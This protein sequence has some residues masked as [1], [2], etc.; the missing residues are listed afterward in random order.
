MNAEDRHLV[1]AIA[2]PAATGLVWAEDGSAIEWARTGETVAVREQVYAT[3]RLLA[4]EGRAPDLGPVAVG[5]AVCALPWNP[6]V[7]PAEHALA[8][9]ERLQSSTAKETLVAIRTRLGVIGST[10]TRV[11]SREHVVAH[12][13][14][15]S[16][17]PD[18]EVDL[19]ERWRVLDPMPRA[20]VVSA[21][22]ELPTQEL[23][24]VDVL[25]SILEGLE[26]TDGQEIL[27]REARGFSGELAPADLES[28]LA[29]DAERVRAVVDSLEAEDDQ[30]S[31][32]A[33]CARIARS[34]MAA[35]RL[36]APTGDRRDLPVGGFADIA[37][38]GSFDRLLL[39]ELAQDEDV[40]MTRIALG[41]A[42]YLRREEPRVQ[43]A[44]D[45]EILMDAGVQTWGM[46]RL[47]V[48][49]AALALGSTARP[50][51]RVVGLRAEGRDV[52]RVDL[53]ERASV[54]RHL[55]ATTLDLHPAAAL[56]GAFSG[57]PMAER[58]VIT[59]AAAL[60]ER[61]FVEGLRTIGDAFVVAVHRSGR[62]RFISSSSAGLVECNE[63]WVD[64]ASLVER[65]GDVRLDPDSE[66]PAYCEVRPAPLR[67][68]HGI[69]SGRQI[70]MRDG[71]AVLGRDRR[72]MI[73]PAAVPPGH[74]LE[75][76]GPVEALVFPRG[77]PMYMDRDDDRVVV[78]FWEPAKNLLH[79]A[80]V[81]VEGQGDVYEVKLSGHPE[82]LTLR[83]DS[84]LVV[85]QA[86]VYRLPEM[87][88]IE[89]EYCP[90]SQVPARRPLGSV[91][92]TYQSALCRVKSAAVV[93]QPGVGPVMAL[94]GASNVYALFV[95]GDAVKLGLWNDAGGGFGRVPQFRE[96]K[97][98]GQRA[99]SGRFLR[100]VTGD[101]GSV[102]W[103]DRRGILHIR[104]PEPTD[105]ELSIALFLQEDLA[106]W[107]TKG[108]DA[109]PDYAFGE[110]RR[111]SDLAFVKW[112]VKFLESAVR[113]SFQ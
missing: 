7:S 93:E 77:A 41:E 111:R 38:R 96:G 40:L 6:A 74:R 24:L 54:E 43:P 47:A 85:D 81:D 21:F 33:H 44:L 67:M 29:D 100:R 37:N 30:D 63:C 64:L 79:C 25:E 26:R 28:S 80:H 19:Q 55:G 104:P 16:S 46:T 110:H 50:G 12:A 69:K 10:G 18:A 68:S 82:G 102:L 76:R 103:F 71:R 4:V 90:P 27:D 56:E 88:L 108:W 32:A 60:H 15:R 42:L 52:F 89:D 31:E 11:P 91:G 23:D 57:G 83:G 99:A 22:A 9:T 98:V 87:E 62:F 70:E 65:S 94:E 8:F 53:G 66:L 34:L 84:L 105:G 3:L 106:A 14:E 17:L 92:Y 95:D 75:Q 109:G 112:M 1:R 39:T 113:E 59:S 73:W 20:S 49:G 58:I 97:P 51:S 36:P 78:A 61:T 2:L 5:L 48:T 107:C 45:R 101:L 35:L 86:S 72:L 13:L